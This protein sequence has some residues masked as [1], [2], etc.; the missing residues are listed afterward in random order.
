MRLCPG[1]RADGTPCRGSA[2]H[3]AEHCRLHGGEVPDVAPDELDRLERE[4]YDAHVAR[5]VARAA[6]LVQVATTDPLATA[7]TRLASRSR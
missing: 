7:A 5:L 3:G 2:V 6:A 1:R 4:L